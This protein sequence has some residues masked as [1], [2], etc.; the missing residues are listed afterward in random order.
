MAKCVVLHS[1]VPYS[2]DHDV[3][4]KNALVPLPDL[5]AVVG[6]DC[7]AWEEAVDWLSVESS[8]YCNT[9]SH[10]QESLQEVITF[11]EQWCELKQWDKDVRVIEI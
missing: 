7:E 8:V 1:T 11:A 6:V 10:P 9:T 5:F 3:A 2:Q 4:L